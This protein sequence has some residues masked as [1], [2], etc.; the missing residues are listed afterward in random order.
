MNINKD[1]IENY[2]DFLASAHDSIV[3]DVHNIS[4]KLAEKIA[5]KIC[6]FL[7]DKKHF[8]KWNIILPCQDDIKNKIEST[9]KDYFFESIENIEEFIRKQNSSIDNCVEQIAS[10]LVIDFEHFTYDAENNRH[11]LEDGEMT[12]IPTEKIISSIITHINFR[13]ES[14]IE[15]HNHKNMID[16][17]GG[18]GTISI[19]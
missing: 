16:N 5:Q 15:Y 19:R 1:I 14:N 4:S 17:A 10:Q 8:E 6:M 12:K 7:E 3:G 11:L 2:I 18:G 9:I 13:N